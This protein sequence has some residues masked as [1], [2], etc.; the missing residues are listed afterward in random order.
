MKK[1]FVLLVLSSRLVKETERYKEV[2]PSLTIHNE[3]KEL[4]RLKV[5]IKDVN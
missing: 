4:K 5:H 2:N 3:I 1:L